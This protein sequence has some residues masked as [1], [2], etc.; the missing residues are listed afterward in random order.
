MKFTSGTSTLSPEPILCPCTDRT[1]LPLTYH[2]NK[3]GE[4]LLGLK[5]TLEVQ[6]LP[7]NILEGRELPGE[8]QS[9]CDS[10]LI[11]GHE[12]AGRP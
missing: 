5:Q 6:E 12:L 9:S 4:R 11:G 3:W 10:H 8:S 7:G 2:A 1:R